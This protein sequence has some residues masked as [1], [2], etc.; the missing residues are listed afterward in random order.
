MSYVA[1][2]RCSRLLALMRRGLARTLNN[3]RGE[4]DA[5]QNVVLFWLGETRRD[6]IDFSVRGIGGHLFPDPIRKCQ[7]LVCIR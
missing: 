5:D 4:V 7:L 2:A 1:A 3:L 6:H